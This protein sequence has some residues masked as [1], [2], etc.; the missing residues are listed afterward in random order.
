V[1]G[2]VINP[3]TDD[4]NTTR[5]RASRSWGSTAWTT[6]IWAVTFDLQ[7][8]SQVIERQALNGALDDDA[9]VVDHAVERRREMLVQARNGRPI[10]DVQLDGMHV[11]HPAKI[12]EVSG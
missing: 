1:P 11:G 6:P 2:K 9:G 3:L 10:G 8:A 5:P 12:S 7:L 4:M